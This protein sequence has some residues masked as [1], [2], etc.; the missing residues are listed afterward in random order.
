MQKIFFFFFGHTLWHAEVPG[1]QGSNPSHSSENTESLTTRLPGN[2][3]NSLCV[4]VIGHFSGYQLLVFLSKFCLSL[5]FLAV[6]LHLYYF[7]CQSFLLIFWCLNNSQNSLLYFDFIKEISHNFFWF[8]IIY[9][10]LSSC[11][12][13][14]LLPVTISI[15]VHHIHSSVYFVNQV[16]NPVRIISFITQLCVRLCQQRTWIETT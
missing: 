3:I 15:F 13:L 10:V 5:T 16:L 9:N 2:S 7:I 12:Y 14:D 11:L 1:P 4:R 6:I 8:L